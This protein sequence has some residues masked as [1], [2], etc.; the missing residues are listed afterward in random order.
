[1]IMVSFALCTI[2]GALRITALA[3][4]GL[5][6]VEMCFLER[7]G[8]LISGLLIAVVGVVVALLDL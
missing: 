1:M 8:D 6:K 5:Y 3:L 4:S 2:G 7:Y